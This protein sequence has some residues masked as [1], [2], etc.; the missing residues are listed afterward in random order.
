MHLMNQFQRV[1]WTH[2]QIFDKIQPMIVLIYET[3][4]L[5]NFVS[6]IL[7]ACPIKE[8]LPVECTCIVKES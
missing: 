1:K 4:Y 7:R 5:L 3:E 6:L 2:H 8:M